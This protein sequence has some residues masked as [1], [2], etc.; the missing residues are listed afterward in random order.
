LI[1]RKNKTVVPIKRVVVVEVGVFCW[2][3]NY[4]VCNNC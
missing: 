3:S 4:K 1:E 2:T